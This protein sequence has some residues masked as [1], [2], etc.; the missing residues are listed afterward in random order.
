MK[1]NNQISNALAS[2]EVRTLI[3]ILSVIALFANLWFYSKIAP[4]LQDQALLNQRVEVLEKSTDT[5]ATI[6][7]SVR[8]TTLE[9][10]LSRIEV[11]LDRIIEGR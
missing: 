4:I 2:P 1:M 8:I 7:N 9:T 11:K 5:S 3:S 10:Q 6:S